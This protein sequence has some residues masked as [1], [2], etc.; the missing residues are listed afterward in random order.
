MTLDFSEH[1]DNGYTHM[2]DHDPQSLNDDFV[3]TFTVSSLPGDPPNPVRDLKDDEFEVTVRKVGVAT[4]LLFGHR[5]D[6]RIP[7]EVG[8]KGFGGEF[9]VQQKDEQE[10]I[11]F[12]AAGV[13]ITPILPSLYSLDYQ[14]LKLLWTV[15]EQD[16]GL[17]LDVLDR[18]PG[19]GKVTEVFIT[20]IEGG[21]D[22]RVKSVEERGAEVHSRRMQQED[23]DKAEGVSRY[24]L[25]TAVPLRKQLSEWLVGKEIVFEDFNF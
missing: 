17:V 16:V 10:R 2:N 22:E 5:I 6:A 7:F 15:R 23:F 20:G 18:H 11:C 12:V 13:G 8:V 14:R 4:N 24:Y 1:L 21:S 3:R 19:L 25:C 9:E